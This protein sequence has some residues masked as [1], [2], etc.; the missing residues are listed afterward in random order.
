MR[1]FA[2]FSGLSS[3]AAF[4]AVSA[5]STSASASNPLDTSYGRVDGD[6]SLVFG[7][8]ATLAPQ[9]PR[10]AAD[11]RIRYIDTLGAFATYEESFGIDTD[12]RRVLAFG[13]E[14]R[15]LFLGRWLQGYEFDSP[16]LDL[17]L[18]SL[19]FEIGAFFAQPQH[20]GSFGDTRGLQAGLGLEVPLME[21]AKG[22]WL[23]FHGGARWSDETFEG[24][25]IGSPNDRSLY[26]TITLSWHVYLGAHVVDIGDT[27]IE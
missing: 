9:A 27:R 1:R 19:G 24:G 14:L 18:D 11:F 6:V 2:R 5:L 25:P 17:L 12:P 23:G 3:L 4:A 26:L 20:A 13:A 10:P 22:I 16:R 21:R 15:P 8:G 7:L